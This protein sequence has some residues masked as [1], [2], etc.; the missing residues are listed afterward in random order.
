MCGLFKLA[1][2]GQPKIYLILMENSMLKNSKKNVM[3]HKFDL[4]GS[5]IARK[6]LSN[7]DM[8]CS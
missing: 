4:K 3:S 2:K 6:V 8:Q 1:V 7:Q 5:K